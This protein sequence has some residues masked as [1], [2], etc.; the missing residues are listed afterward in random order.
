M[1][2]QKYHVFELVETDW[3]SSLEKK[4]NYIGFNKKKSTDLKF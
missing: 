2:A 3:T 1:A 4:R